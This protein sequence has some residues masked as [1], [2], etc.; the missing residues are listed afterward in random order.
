MAYSLQYASFLQGSCPL[1]DNIKE[2]VFQ[3]RGLRAQQGINIYYTT[4]QGISI[5]CFARAK[6]AIQVTSPPQDRRQDKGF[7]YG[8][9]ASVSI[10]L[11][12]CITG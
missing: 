5:R 2:K 10:A 12:P 9:R 7:Q 6:Y 4:A 11:Q 8:Q 3:Y 1:Q